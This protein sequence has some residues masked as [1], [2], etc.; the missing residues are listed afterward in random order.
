[1]KHDVSGLLIELFHQPLG[2][3]PGS[4]GC[5]QQKPDASA[6][7]LMKLSTHRHTAAHSLE[8]KARGSEFANHASVISRKDVTE[9]HKID[10][11]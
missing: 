4:V 7:R 8:N 2:A 10:I 11:L 9:R 5:V 1:M 3:S 6:F